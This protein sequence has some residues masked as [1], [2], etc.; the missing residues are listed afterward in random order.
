MSE[1]AISRVHG[2]DGKGGKSG[3][4]GI[5]KADRGEDFVS[6]IMVFFAWIC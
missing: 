4:F 5:R 3:I 1:A 2:G 6:G